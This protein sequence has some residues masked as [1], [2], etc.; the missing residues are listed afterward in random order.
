MT[1]DIKDLKNWTAGTL[2]EA[3][4]KITL[5]KDLETFQMRGEG[6]CNKIL[7]YVT[8]DSVVL[9]FGCGI[10]RVMLPLSKHVKEIHGVD[11]SPDML[12]YAREYLK[13]IGN[14]YLYPVNG[15]DMKG[16]PTNKFDFVYSFITLQHIMS[17]RS[18][19]NNLF[20]IK[21]VLKYKGKAYLTFLDLK[22][23]WYNFLEI[24]PTTETT[25]MH[26]R[27]EIMWLL[28][29]IGLRLLSEEHLYGNIELVVQKKYDELIY[30]YFWYEESMNDWNKI[31][32]ELEDINILG[33][34]GIVIDIEP[35]LLTSYSNP[36]SPGLS[37]GN[38]DSGIG[39][40]IGN[41]RIKNSY[42]KTYQFILSECERLHMTV[43]PI[44]AFGAGMLSNDFFES[45]PDCIA[46]DKNGNDVPF[47]LSPDKKTI[48][49]PW[50]T[51][52]NYKVISYLENH[53]KQIMNIHKKSNAAYRVDGK[54][55]VEI[56]EDAGY[57]KELD[58][59]YCKSA[60][61]SGVDKKHAIAKFLEE[62]VK[63]CHD[64]YDCYCL[65]HAYRDGRIFH[66]PKVM[67]N[68]GLD[69]ELFSNVCDG[70]MDTVAP[71]NCDYEYYKN[72]Y[73]YM[74]KCNHGKLIFPVIS[75]NDARF[76]IMPQ[77]DALNG[78]GPTAIVFYPYNDYPHQG[79]NIKNIEKFRSQIQWLN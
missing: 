38:P 32:S 5:D 24:S 51:Y 13:N 50:M 56:L 78:F 33:F 46:K 19:V 62:L 21:R 14:V 76:D 41:P 27:E 79:I 26:T 37:T 53:F 12:R 15:V 73:N 54:M 29:T 68:M 70:Q 16:F 64:K 25:C 9:D 45:N 4:Y 34:N 22:K 60:I 36:D 74:A 7:P 63:W 58:T 1:E 67:E 48:I 39:N 35:S 10:G 61:Y 55:V 44:L 17:K 66:D 57:P 8:K 20:E 47:V 49:T 40:G 65:Y 77:I 30:Y 11:I 59:D 42:L 72:G 2:Q 31:T 71:F 23:N 43:L 6:D 75:C 28:K 3:I 69:Y 52:Y 18:L